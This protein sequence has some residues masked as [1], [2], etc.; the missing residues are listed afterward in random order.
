MG[1]PSKVSPPLYCR[2]NWTVFGGAPLLF[3]YLGK[4]TSVSCRGS[5]PSVCFGGVGGTDVKNHLGPLGENGNRSPHQPCDQTTWF[6]LV[7]GRGENKIVHASCAWSEQRP[8]HHLGSPPADR[9]G[10]LGGGGVG[11]PPWGFVGAPIR[12]KDPLVQPVP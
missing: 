9:G 11:L 5:C 4:K 12:A 1:F 6:V 10:F 3:V 8:G 2:G 7:F